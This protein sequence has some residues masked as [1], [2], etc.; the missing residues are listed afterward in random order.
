MALGDA[1]NRALQLGGGGDVK[2]N[3]ITV[4]FIFYLIQVRKIP[5]FKLI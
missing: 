5:L 1:L 3:D 4:Y 2:A